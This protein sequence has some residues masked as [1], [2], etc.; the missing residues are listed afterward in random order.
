MSHRPRSL[1]GAACVVAVASLLV[2]GCGLDDPFSSSTLPPMPTNP[3][4]GGVPGDTSLTTGTDPLLEIDTSP[5]TPRVVGDSCAFTDAP[6]PGSTDTVTYTFGGRLFELSD[7]ATTATCLAPVTDKQV[8]TLLWSPVGDRFLVGPNQVVV[9]DGVAKTGFASDG[10]MPVWSAPDGE[11]LFGAVDGALVRRTTGRTKKATVN[12]L[13]TVQAVA[14]YP[15]G[16]FILVAGT[17]KEGSTVL[18]LSTPDG[19]LW[20]PLVML[21]A[22]TAITDL[23]VNPEGT[24]VAFTSGPVVRTVA[25]PD[26]TISTRIQTEGDVRRLTVRGA[27]VAA[28]VGDCAA[29]TSTRMFDGTTTV[30]LNAKVP[31]LGRSTEPVG[32]VGDRLI[33]LSRLRGCEGPADL[34]A[35]DPTGEQV[36]TL[37]VSAVERAAVRPAPLPPVE[38]PPGMPQQPAQG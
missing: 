22:G 20:R 24:T 26:L 9:P 2:G 31:F 16:A 25:L 37:L 23:A 38:F 10:P 13:D 7:D 19:K 29:Q 17:V 12:L 14:F 30:D 18:A 27:V 36:P 35:V 11:F 15:G 32:F 5:R 28:R 21:P 8:G 34:W 3:A 1:L 6:V 33:V 4:A